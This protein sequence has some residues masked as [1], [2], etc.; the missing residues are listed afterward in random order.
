P[1]ASGAADRQ[2][3]GGVEQPVQRLG[4]ARQGIEITLHRLRET[5][6]QAPGRLAL[7]EL[8]VARRAGRQ[9]QSTRQRAS[10]ASSGVS[11]L[12]LGRARKPSS[13]SGSRKRL[14]RKTV[15]E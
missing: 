7:T 11:K 14:P 10:A 5:V 3:T 4:A 2:P 13:V 12:S 1:Y 9:T 8:G 15:A 6:E